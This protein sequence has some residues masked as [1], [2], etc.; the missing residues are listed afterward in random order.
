MKTLK[1]LEEM[2]EKACVPF[3][4]QYEFLFARLEN[5]YIS[6][7]DGLARIEYELA[8]WDKD[9]QQVI[10]EKLAEMISTSGIMGF[11]KNEILS[12]VK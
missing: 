11:D 10:A 6:K 12:L 8:Q 5:D 4:T 1:D 7:M 2:K 3:G 9:A